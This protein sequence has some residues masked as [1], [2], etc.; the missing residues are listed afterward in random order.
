MSTVAAIDWE[1]EILDLLD[2]LS[3]VQDALF[4]VLSEKRACM[5]R[6]DLEAMAAFN[7]REEEVRQRLEN[8]HTR[9]QQLL[10]AARQRSLSS[11]SLQSLAKTGTA[12][13]SVNLGKQV[14]DATSRLRLLQHESL[15]NWVIAQRSLLHYAQMLEI[16]ATGGQPDPTYKERTAPVRRGGTLLDQEA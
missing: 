10:R 13:S 2:E 7:T 6:H 15:T 4:G 16:L 3:Q 8:C 1:A 11:D 9:R 12:G 5:A 14:N